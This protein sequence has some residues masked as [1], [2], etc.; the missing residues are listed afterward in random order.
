MNLEDSLGRTGCLLRDFAFEAG[1]S[2]IVWV[3]SSVLQSLEPDRC[4]GFWLEQSVGV[5][6]LNQDF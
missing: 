5:P 3:T 1:L 4:P 2:P 6:E